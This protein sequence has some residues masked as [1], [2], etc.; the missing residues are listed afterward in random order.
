[1]HKIWIIAI[2][3]FSA[4]VRSKAFLISLVLMPLMMFGGI[5]VQ[6]LT[7]KISDVK[8]RRIAIVDHTS[9]AALAEAVAREAETRNKTRI[10]DK[11]VKD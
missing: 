3:E 1:L 10:F 6:K 9:S 2:R 11:E 4:A 5:F 7:Q 8:P